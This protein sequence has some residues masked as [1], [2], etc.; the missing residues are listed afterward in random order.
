MYIISWLFGI[1]PRPSGRTICSTYARMDPVSFACQVNSYLICSPNLIR[2]NFRV[3]DGRMVDGLSGQRLVPNFQPC[4]TTEN[5]NFELFKPQ[6][7]RGDFRQ[8][9]VTLCHIFGA[10]K[11]PNFLP[12]STRLRAKSHATRQ[13]TPSSHYS[14]LC[15]SYVLHGARPRLNSLQDQ[16]QLL[17]PIVSYH[18]T[19]A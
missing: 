1:A 14:T 19:S 7:K 6:K 5:P 18:D 3:V 11:L 12:N 10:K 16:T 13:P 2:T 17:V 8:T 9:L 4:F 15:C